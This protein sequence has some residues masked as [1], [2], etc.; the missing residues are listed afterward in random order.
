MPDE[1]DADRAARRPHAVLVRLPRTELGS[2]HHLHPPASRPSLQREAAREGDAAV[3][4]P[5]AW[6]WCQGQPRLGEARKG[7]CSANDDGL[8][9]CARGLVLMRLSACA[10]WVKSLHEVLANKHCA[11]GHNGSGHRCASEHSHIASLPGGGT[12]H[13]PGGN[14]VRLGT[15]IQGGAKAGVV[16]NVVKLVQ[17]R[18][19]P[20]KADLEGFSQSQR[21]QDDSPNRLWNGCCGDGEAARPPAARGIKG[22]VAAGEAVGHKDARGPG[23][24]GR[25]KLHHV[26]A[27]PSL[28]HH[29]LSPGAGRV[30]E[31]GAAV[32]RVC[33]HQAELDVDDVPEIGADKA[34]E[35]AE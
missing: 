27:G 17:G 20:A 6:R 7:R 19:A 5:A 12:G 15:P 30:D 26:I 2:I 9:Q 29:K 1:G 28:H 22:E 4:L 25:L 24:L 34:L 23:L 3:A 13:C 33:R 31:V 10:A 16:C 11:T 32:E 35:D 14:D 8:H 21:Q 18:G